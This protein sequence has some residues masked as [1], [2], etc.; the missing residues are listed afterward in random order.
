MTK[1]EILKT[2]Y[3]VW[4]R[5]FYLNTSLSHVARELKVCKPALYRHFLNKNALL[6]AMTRHF[7]DDFAAF[8]QADYEKAMKTE[9]KNESAFILVRSITEYYARN[10]DFFIFAMT[11]LN[12]HKLDSFNMLEE[13]CI[14][15]IDMDSRFYQKRIYF[16]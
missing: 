13:L 9:D 12:D 7:F 16:R 15:G 8:I 14:R 4:G 3:K 5:E 11:I 6:E 10:V 2:A 1:N